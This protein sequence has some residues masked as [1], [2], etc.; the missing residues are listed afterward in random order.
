[1]SECVYTMHTAIIKMCIVQIFT[2]PAY[3]FIQIKFYFIFLR[4]AQYQLYVAANIY[5][6]EQQFKQSIGTIFTFRTVKKLHKL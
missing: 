4:G 1:M 6:T 2:P 3:I 5:V